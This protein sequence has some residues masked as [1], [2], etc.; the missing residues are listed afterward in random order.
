VRVDG[1]RAATQFANEYDTV[2]ED[3]SIAFAADPFTHVRVRWD[4]PEEE[5][6]F[7]YLGD[8]IVYDRTVFETA[9]DADASEATITYT[10]EQT[11]DTDRLE[12]KHRRDDQEGFPDG[13]PLSEYHDTLTAGD[14]IVVEDVTPGDQVSI[15]CTVEVENGTYGTSV[16]MLS[17]RPPGYFGVKRENGQTKVVYFGSSERSAIDASVEEYRVLV[18]GEPA[19]TQ[20]ADE[21]DELSKED[22]IELDAGLGSEVTVE[23]TGENETIEMTSRVVTPDVRFAFERLDDGRVEIT[24]NGGE[25][26]DAGELTVLVR[27]H[28]DPDTDS[29]SWGESGETVEKGD[30]ITVDVPEDMQGI[31]I[32][33]GDRGIVGERFDD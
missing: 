22:G 24:H 27:P 1:E 5:E 19:A 10:G 33:Y 30:S 31:V 29:I 18:D 7:D 4:D 17:V 26:V 28:G 2:E 23:W 25:P 13:T 8:S 6:T 15:S 20:F 16:A 14:E 11:A 3:D 21:Y 32:K 12:L 9:Y